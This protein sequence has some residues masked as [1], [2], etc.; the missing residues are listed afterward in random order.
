MTITNKQ[1]SLLS[2][3]VLQITQLEA[4]YSLESTDPLAIVTAKELALAFPLGT[5]PKNFVKIRPRFI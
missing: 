4:K 3:Y 5:F 2:V 1:H